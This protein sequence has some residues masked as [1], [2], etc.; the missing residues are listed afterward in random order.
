MP[1]D[2]WQADLLPAGSARYY[3]VLQQDSA[4]QARLKSI[5]QLQ[6]I[7]SRAGFSHR[8]TEA[9]WLKL[10]WWQREL[11]DNQQRHPLS[12]ALAAS[13][14]ANPALTT[15]LLHVLKGYRDLTRN[16]SPGGDDENT[17]FHHLT[18][19]CACL[20]LA[21]CE[22]DTDTQQRVARLGIALSKWRCLRYLRRH[23]AN[24]LLCL[25]KSRLDAAGISPAKLTPE[26]SQPELQH[27][28]A[29]E[30]ADVRTALEAACDEMLAVPLRDAKALYVYADLQRRLAAT[31]A[32]SNT[33]LMQTELRLTPLKNLWFAGSA[34]RRYERQLARSG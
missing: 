23:V 30:L 1:E 6:Q 21:N 24:G 3:A 25:P 14:E 32:K 20:A 22:D 33:Q 29:Q 2:L 19:A 12:R 15:Q 5:L 17:R 4:D 9:T 18:G 16:G 13:I 8:P 10:D 26:N 28:L 31:V 27:F 11:E 7:W 34:S